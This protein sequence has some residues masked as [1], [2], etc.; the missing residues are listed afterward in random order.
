[1]KALIASHGRFV[2]GLLA[3]ATAGTMYAGYKIP[4][5]ILAACACGLV[6]A[7]ERLRSR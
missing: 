3:L 6:I 5:L 4:G 7:A 2:G 1:M